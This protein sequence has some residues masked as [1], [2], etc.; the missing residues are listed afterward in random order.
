ME[1]QI[2]DLW[3][4]EVQALTN[5]PGVYTYKLFK[6]TREIITGAWDAMYALENTTH[7]EGLTLFLTKLVSDFADATRE[8]KTI[9]AILDQFGDSTKIRCDDE[10]LLTLRPDSWGWTLTSEGSSY[11]T[12]R[13]ARTIVAFYFSD[14]VPV[15]LLVYVA[16]DN[17][18]LE[19]ASTK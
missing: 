1:I 11:V 12:I 19:L 4:A 17:L 10:S 15:F 3:H 14:R 5:E 16:G 6:Q 13:G 9:K 2:D 7:V 8:L 18:R